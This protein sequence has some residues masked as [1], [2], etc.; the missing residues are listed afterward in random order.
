MNIELP[1]EIPFDRPVEG[2]PS[3]FGQCGR[4]HQVAIGPRTC[5]G[6]DAKLP[7][8]GDPWPRSEFAELWDDIVFAYNHERPEIA[9]VVSAEYFEASV[10]DLIYW[11]T[12]WLDPQLNWIGAAF[13]E[14]KSKEERIW[15]YLDQ[16]RSRDATDEALQRLF[17]V[18]GRQML[19]KVLGPDAVPFWENYCRLDD[20]RNR[21]V[22][23]GQRVWYRTI[24]PQQDP[25]YAERILR[26]SMEWV[27]T[28]WVVFSRLWNEYIHKAMHGNAT[29][30]GH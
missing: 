7:H 23:R 24:A 9:A 8:G 10:F 12:V 14:V 25:L 21:I 27:P 30:G 19:E 1:I 11:G 16:I 2:P 3:P 4:C 28:C 22:H 6:C 20:L 17:A 15:V 13:E 26:A 29:P 18:T 5:S